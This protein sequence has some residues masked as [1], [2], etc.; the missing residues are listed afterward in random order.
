MTGTILPHKGVFKLDPS[1]TLVQENIWMRGL[2]A[3]KGFVGQA[4]N[5]GYSL[6]RILRQPC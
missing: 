4:P 5:T 3:R 2:R 6:Q 1:P